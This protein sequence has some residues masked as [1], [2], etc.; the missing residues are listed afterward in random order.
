MFISSCL[1]TIQLKF[2]NREI[3]KIKSCTCTKGCAKKTA[4]H[5]F[6]YYVWQFQ[7]MIIRI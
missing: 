2:K 6:K 1:T 5:V 7:Y 4:E 3:N